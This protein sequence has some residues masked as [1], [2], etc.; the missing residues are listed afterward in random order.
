MTLSRIIRALELLEDGRRYD[1]RSLPADVADEVHIAL[2]E[3]A[4]DLAAPNRVGGAHTCPDCSATFEWPG[5]LER[6][7]IVS[8]HGIAEAA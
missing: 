2:A 4:E 5:L 6:H 8:G 1:D 3:L 7:L